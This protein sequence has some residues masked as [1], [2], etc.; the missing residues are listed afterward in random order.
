M[1]INAQPDIEVAAQAG[2]GRGALRIAQSCEIDVALL[3]VSMPDLGGADTAERLREHCPNVRLIA[4]TR[5]TDQGYV[6]RML[7]AAPPGMC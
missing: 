2:G 5:H 1:L 3:D 7:R 6:S 4:L